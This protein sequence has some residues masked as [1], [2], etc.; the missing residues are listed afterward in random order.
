[1][2]RPSSSDRSPKVRTRHGEASGD[3]Y[4]LYQDIQWKAKYAAAAIAERGRHELERKKLIE[5]RKQRWKQRLD[6]A[7]FVA[8]HLDQL[9]RALERLPGVRVLV[10]AVGLGIGAW[11]LSIWF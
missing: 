7:R 4:A 2:W 6:I 11:L 10:G 5:Q 9:V 1:V 8:H 3:T